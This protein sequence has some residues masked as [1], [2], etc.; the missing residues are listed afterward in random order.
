MSEIEKIII[1][2]DWYPFDG[3]DLDTVKNIIIGYEN[4]WSTSHS[5]L[6]DVYKLRVA[7]VNNLY[8]SRGDPSKTKTDLDAKIITIY[9]LKPVPNDISPTA[10]K[11]DETDYNMN[12]LGHG[13]GHHD[14][15][16]AIL[17]EM[18]NCKINRQALPN[19]RRKFYDGLISL[20][21]VGIEIAG[22]EGAGMWD[23]IKMM[24]V[25]PAAQR[26]YQSNRDVYKTRNI[27]TDIKFAEFFADTKHA[28]SAKSGST[29]LLSGECYSLETITLADYNNVLVATKNIGVKLLGLSK[30][31]GVN[32]WGE[33]VDLLKSKIGTNKLNNVGLYLNAFELIN[34]IAGTRIVTA[35]PPK[36]H[37]WSF[38]TPMINASKNKPTCNVQL[39]EL[40]PLINNLEQSMTLPPKPGLTDIEIKQLSGTYLHVI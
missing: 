25:I 4:I 21:A 26:P 40:K 33:I 27:Q 37:E 15:A 13:D 23:Y 1:P 29:S 3:N 2:N 34:K 20:S 9:S 5:Q 16:A 11:C 35:K 30:P 12:E 36:L 39:K 28:K 6:W 31:N 19:I 32:A 14:I 7:S 8:V 38:N 22:V 24:R 10:Q 17:M 18:G